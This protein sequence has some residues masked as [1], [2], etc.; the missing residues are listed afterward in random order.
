[1]IFRCLFIVCLLFINLVFSQ[2]KASSL[3]TR[4]KAFSEH[5]SKEEI[6]DS[7]IEVQNLSDN[8]QA[9]FYVALANYQQ[10][11][12]RDYE[13]ASKNY[14]LALEFKNIPSYTKA[15]ALNGV[16]TI[17]GRFFQNKLALKKYK[18]SLEIILKHHK[19]SIK[20]ITSLYNNIG[21]LFSKESIRDSAAYYFRKGIDFGNKNNIPAMG[22]YFNLGYWHK[23]PDSSYY[24][25]KK[26]LEATKI[27]K[28]DYLLTFCYLNLGANEIARKNYKEADS[29]LKLSKENALRFK[30]ENYLNELKIQDAKLLIIRNQYKK[31]VDLLENILPYFYKRTPDY[32]QLETIYTWLENGYI[33]LENFKKAH[34]AL[35]KLNTN[36]KERENFKKLQLE[37]GND[38][39]LEVQKILEEK[40]TI[41]S[42]QKAIYFW[43]IIL[44]I[45][46]ILIGYYFFKKHKLQQE[47]KVDK[48][49]RKNKKL[50]SRVHTLKDEKLLTHQQLLFK[51]LL[52]DEK[53]SFLKQLANDI[54]S[55]ANNSSSSNKKNLLNI[56]K[57]I[58][59]NIKDNI[60]DEFEY[61]FN[62]VH[63]NFYKSFIDKNFE[64]SK[65]EM[66]LAALIKLNFSTKEISD[67]TKQTSNTI[68]VAKSRLK[69][70]LNLNKEDSL[71]NFIQ[72]TD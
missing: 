25:T 31:G 56:Y 48:I 13:N 18:K 38:Y 42:R 6:K 1:M 61:H 57:K 28:K 35:Q 41:N 24:Y 52:V 70:K 40:N 68:N 65:N 54:Q 69:S 12:F 72:N 9:D 11:I 44:L 26:A 55:L 16:G 33:K 36:N 53:Q 49:T 66:R 2:K 32:N 22:C 10:I 27:L 67:I 19:D 30:Q 46:G 62:K 58:K 3:T 21:H 4:L 60:G 37:K 63:P 64:L 45:I 39:H 17:Y 34:W 50:S 71:Y 20:D 14:Y 5:V 51:N 15:D 59:Q 47:K 8:K 43:I 23:N 29:L 7:I